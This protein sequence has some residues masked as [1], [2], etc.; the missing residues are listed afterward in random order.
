VTV[1]EDRQIVVWDVRTQAIVRQTQEPDALIKS[2]ALGP[3]A[4]WLVLGTEH[5]QLA[6]FR[7]GAGAN[8]MGLAYEDRIKFYDLQTGL[9]AKTVNNLIVEPAAVALSADYKY[10]AVAQRDTKVSSVG[11]FD[12]DRGVRIAELPSAAKATRVEFSPNG[13]WF[14]FGDD[15]GQLHTFEVKGVFPR[16]ATVADLAGRKYSLTSASEPLVRPA[17]RVR[18]AVLDLDNLGVDE[19]VAKL[20]GDQL[21]NRLAQNPFVRLVERRRLERVIA[22]QNLQHSGRTDPATATRLARILNVQKVILGSVGK[23]GSTMTIYTQLVDVETGA[24]EGAREMQCRNCSLED[25]PQAVSEMSS[26]LVAPAPPGTAAL[27]SPP[28]I[29]IDAPGDGAQ[30]RGGV[31]TLQG[32]VSYTSELEGIEL[33][34]NGQAYPASRIFR[35]PTSGRMTKLGGG[36]LFEFVQ[37][38]PLVERS[39]LIAVRAVSMDGNDEQQYI[40]VERAP[41]ATEPSAEGD[42]STAPTSPARPREVRRDAPSAAA[43]TGSRGPGLSLRELEDALRH[44]IPPDQL[45]RLI[46]EFGLAF[47]M[48]PTEE[49]RLRARG[50]TSALILK[51]VAARSR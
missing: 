18:F 8:R 32:R 41:S 31:V 47:K 40:N 28:R 1:G 38:V 7:G 13:R 24:I 34:V 21:T 27:P 43:M 6:G 16:G 3:G 22:E 19:F 29:E 50:A 33:V 36:E 2:A 48:G 15:R 49:Q 30:V 4:D 10:V 5:T 35:A 20:I 37:Q 9:V 23:L 46:D 26:S 51:L 11:W 17:R 39:N 42:R 25:L 44:S 12:V 45:Y 14:V